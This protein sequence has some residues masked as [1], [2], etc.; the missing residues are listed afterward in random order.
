MLKDLVQAIVTQPAVQRAF[1]RDPQ[2]LFGRFDVT[3]T[4]RQLLLDQ[5]EA[6][7]VAAL[8]AELLSRLRAVQTGAGV[9]VGYPGVAELHIDKVEPHELSAKKS[10]ELQIWLK[11]DHGGLPQKGLPPWSHVD[12]V[13]KD[14]TVADYGA[15]FSVPTR[16]DFDEQ[17]ALI[18][19]K[20]QLDVPGEYT[21]VV[22]FLHP[23]VL[24]PPPASITVKA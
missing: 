21:L 12:V 20:V 19:R 6:G 23:E 18:R 9:G 24:D 15:A 14:G 10:V 7:L 11:W 2:S 17:T 16:L 4:E 13:K 5:N 1:E 8:G 3:Q 22:R